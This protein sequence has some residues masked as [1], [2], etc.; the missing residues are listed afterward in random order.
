M[1]VNVL[2]EVPDNVPDVQA[3]FVEPLAAALEISEQLHIKPFE[4]V[5]VL[6]DGK[7]GL[8]TALAL[9]AQNLDV[10]LVGKHQNKLDK[11][12]NNHFQLLVF[13]AVAFCSCR[14]RD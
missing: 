7:L 11:L 9:K 14:F 13:L 3:V 10:I 8:I 2:F 4:K 6:G 5:M 12:A 1:P